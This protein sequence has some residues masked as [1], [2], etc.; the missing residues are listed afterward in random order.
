MN[1]KSRFRQVPPRSVVIPFVLLAAVLSTALSAVLYLVTD[2]S[3][4]VL[5]WTALGATSFLYFGLDKIWAQK[6]QR[7]IPEVV[8]HGLTLLGGFLGTAAGMVVLRHKVRKPVFW[9]V[10]FLGGVVHLTLALFWP[11]LLR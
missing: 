2:W 7:R 3:A 9:V 6:Q 4:Y 5:W 1:R 10:L 8:L 11:G